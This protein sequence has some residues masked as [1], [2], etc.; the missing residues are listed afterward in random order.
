M[1]NDPI[2]SAAIAEA[3]A[4][5]TSIADVSLDRIARRAGVSR[6]TMFRRVRSREALEAAV[7]AAGV[8]P[9]RRENV[10]DRALGAATS[11]IVE[12][13]VG[14]LTVEEVARQISCATTSIH[15]QFGGR[16]GLLIAVFERHAP[17][18]VVEQLLASRTEPFETFE[19]GV[20]AVY[21][22]VF[23]ALESDQGVMEALVAEALARPSGDVM[24]LARERIIPRILATVG[25]WL[26]AEIEAGRCIRLP[27]SL[28]LP[29][30]IAPVAVHMLAR[31]RLV[32]A[33]VQVPDRQ[34]VVDTVAGT[35]C[36]AVG[37]GR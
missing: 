28:L 26:T 29:Q 7:R 32:A 33:G 15:T 12:R 37:T 13:G 23:D 1:T 35:F 4:S 8:D 19:A 10:R 34:T 31:R 9:G 3:E 27:F 24:R 36:R 2:V 16:E 6:S 21:T 14:A 17:L 20:R 5:G 25:C 18:P 11:L 30:L 22:A